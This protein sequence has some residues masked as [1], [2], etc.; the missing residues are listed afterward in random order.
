MI[1]PA[2]SKLADFIFEIYI[3]RQFRRCFNRV[4][5]I[6]PPLENYQK[7]ILLVS[8]HSSWWDGFIHYLLN[9]KIFNKKYHILML[10]NQLKRFW[11]FNKLGAFSINRENNKEI[12]KS[13]AFI[14]ELSKS[15]SKNNLIVFFPQGE[16][17][18]SFIQPIGIKKGFEK[19]IK[20]NE[21][22]DIIPMSYLIHSQEEQLPILYINISEI[23]IN[24]E[25]IGSI[26][27][28]IDN[29][30]NEIKNHIINKGKETV[31][32]QGKKSAGN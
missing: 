13:F 25:N 22:C 7:N 4:V 30:Q 27:S 15:E 9:K 5:L 6:N 29:L 17:L 1:K 26:E 28:I 31:I 3:L 19:L 24:S 2:H 10:E 32:L 21:N 16:I 12:I 18:P 8:N 20:C 11:F 23:S 14:N